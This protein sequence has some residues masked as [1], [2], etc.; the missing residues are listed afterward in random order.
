MQI[1]GWHNL[2]EQQNINKHQT[3]SRLRKGLQRQV[4]EP[5]GVP[6]HW[7]WIWTGLP[8]GFDILAEALPSESP[9]DHLGSPGAEVMVRLSWG[10]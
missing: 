4:E 10:Q 2:N 1:I 9:L 5:G 8:V 3:I 6:L 7:A